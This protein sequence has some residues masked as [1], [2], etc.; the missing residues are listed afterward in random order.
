MSIQA[1]Q[2]PLLDKAYLRHNIFQFFVKII[3]FGDK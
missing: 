2:K 1:L 3:F